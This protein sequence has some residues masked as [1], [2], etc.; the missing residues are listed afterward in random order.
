MPYYEWSYGCT[1]TSGAML[2][3]WWDAHH[4]FGR[5]TQYQVTRWD[6]VQDQYDHHVP[7]TQAWLANAMGTDSEGGTL[8]WNI[9]N[10]LIDVAEDLGYGC[11]SDGWWGP[12]HTSAQIFT[13]IAEQIDLDRPCMVSIP[14][15][16][17]VGVGYALEPKVVH[18]HDPNFGTLQTLSRS[19]LDGYHYAVLS[20]SPGVNVEVVS[21]NGGTEWGSNG[22]YTETL[23]SGQYFEVIWDCEYPANT[24]A[25]LYYNDEGG[26]D[27]HWELITDNTA[28]DGVYDWLVPAISS[29]QGN[30]TDFARLKVEIYD[31]NTNQLLG[32]DG[33]YGNF[34]ILAGGGLPVLGGPLV[35]VNSPAFYSVNNTVADSWGVIGVTDL[36][37]NGYDVWDMELYTSPQFTTLVETSLDM[38]DS[39]NYMV[40][41]NYQLSPQ[42]WGV[43]FRSSNPHAD[44]NVMFTSFPGFNLVSGSPLLGDWPADVPALAWNVYLEPGSYLFSLS[45]TNT[46]ADLNLALFQAGGNGIFNPRDAIA[47]ST[48]IGSA[49]E[50]FQYNISTAGYY[51]L[52]ASARNPVATPYTIMVSNSATWTGTLSNDWFTPGNWNTGVVPDL[53]MN[54]IIPSGAINSPLIVGGIASPAYV[55][56]LTIM[57]NAYMTVADGMI[58]VYGDLTVSG[59]LTQSHSNSVID[60]SGSFIITGSGRYIVTADANLYC[61]T[62]WISMV[63]A[64]AELTQGT[65]TFLSEQPGVID[66]DSNRV[67]FRNVVIN[68]PAGNFYIS[69]GCLEDVE[70]SNELRIET[71]SVLRSNSGRKIV[72]TGPIVKNGLIQLEN[73]I[74]EFNGSQAS[75]N[76]TTLDY[77]YSLQINTSQM[78]TLNTHLTVLKNLSIQAGGINAGNKTIY[79]GGDW[80]NL[81][82]TD[83]FIEGTSVVEFVGNGRAS[84]EGEHFATLRIDNPNCE[85]YFDTGTTLVDSYDW[86]AGTLHVNG[87]TLTIADLYDD[88]LTGRTIVSNGYL[89][90]TQDASQHIDLAGE[91]QIHGG[92]LRLSGGFGLSHWPWGSNASLTMTGGILHLPDGGIS[93][94]A[95]PY[96][97][98]ANLT[99]G[100]IRLA[101]SLIC[102]RTDFLPTGGTFELIPTGYNAEVSCAAPSKFA[103]LLIN[104]SAPRETALTESRDGN[105][106]R[107]NTVYLQS[108]LTLSGNLMVVSGQ[109]DLNGFTLNVEN[110]AEISSIL[111]MQNTYDLLIVDD[112][113]FWNSGSVGI[114]TTGEV[115]VN[116]WLVIEPEAEFQMAASTTLTFFGT[117]NGRISNLSTSTTFGNLNLDKTDAEVANNIDCLP[118]TVLGNLQINSTT[119]FYIDTYA[120]TVNGNLIGSSQTNLYLINGG[121]LTINGNFNTNGDMRV[122]NGA[123][124]CHGTYTHSILGNLELFQ[125]SF[126]LDRAFNSSVPHYISSHVL[127]TGGL[128]N[129]VHNA[130]VFNEGAVFEMTGGTVR[131]GYDFRANYAGNF[132]PVG[133]SVE[134]TGARNSTLRMVD[135]NWFYDLKFNKPSTSYGFVFNTSVTASNDVYVMGGVASLSNDVL[136]VGRDLLISGGRLACNNATDIINVGRNWTNTAGRTAFTEGP[137]TVNFVST[138]VGTIGSEDFNIVNINKGSAEINDLLIEAGAFVTIN[139]NLG[140]GGS[141]C[142][143]LLPGST[144]DLNANVNINGGLDITSDGATNLLYLAGDLWDETDG[145]ADGW[146]FK[147]NQGCTFIFNGSGDQVFGGDYMVGSETMNLFNVTVNKS[148][149]RVLPYNPYNIYGAFR[150]ISGEWYY[151]EASLAKNFHGDFLVE[152]NGIYSDNTGTTNLTGTAD[153]SF[154]A[155]GAVQFGILSFNKSATTNVNLTGDAI[156]S[157]TTAINLYAGIL[158]VGANTFRYK[159]SL[160]IGTNGKLNLSAGSVLKID[161]TSTLTVNAGGEFVSVGT[162][163]NPA[164][165]TSD[166]GYYT[167]T[168]TAINCYVAAQY[169]IFEKMGTSGIN[170][171]NRCSVDTGNVFRGCT[172]RNG[173]AGGTLLTINVQV[174]LEIYY[175]DFPANTWG[176]AY[177]VAR[178]YAVG[179]VTFRNY[180]GAFSGTAFHNSPNNSIF[181]IDLAPLAPQNLVIS[182]NGSAAV[183]SWD[184][185]TGVTGYHIYRSFDV[186]DISSAALVGTTSSTTWNDTGLP[187]N[188]KA[189]YFVKAYTE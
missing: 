21:P 94:D 182:Q 151:G 65:V 117:S 104:T 61:Y 1:P 84:C 136:S 174:P 25:K 165:V 47:S 78:N 41:N 111:I 52:I 18:I 126:T 90:I 157:G 158:N 146:G 14:E 12:Q 59:Q 102:T 39:Y 186:N 122:E 15:H 179:S 143:K 189:F 54:V 139:G 110:E 185:V 3:A 40:L 176:G 76:C 120:L 51:G 13:Q 168:A 100:T 57:S 75:L 70:I 156:L 148:A 173:I 28:N 181:W 178:S 79:I 53:N 180:T 161:D 124:L 43:K 134:L 132:V 119:D 30:F 67:N 2:F 49:G 98:T 6:P 184:A 171:G 112:G 87:G 170:L 63:S 106:T 154:K 187:A 89:Y 149:G 103:N 74:V 150:I 116:R 46:L 155:L 147:A 188:P 152:A 83:G 55:K 16:S 160:N 123:F 175:A 172:F 29:S 48:L 77:F 72:I 129:V 45:F 11:I 127:V 86:S 34:T 92:L 80:I 37:D 33:S 109:L 142:L 128:L 107:F 26:A 91:L 101:G 166:L 22:S 93:I 85:L 81:M 9:D 82:G 88:G 133:G 144:L 66:N 121:A 42:Y 115:R 137:G 162:S 32:S 10:G 5:F 4:G 58:N 99:G 164:L 145:V 8:V 19:Q 24:Y 118:I 56:S 169:T 130:I 62:N 95:S 183:L 35:T 68:K 50:S 44:A 159:G 60:V 114:I 177:N 125:G 140:I 64:R 23:V 73:G 7:D 96:T 36:T 71:G 108:D 20:G 113:L 131:T 17:V 97:F 163:S 105:P 153:C 135:G 27:N 141:S 38:Y 69:E 138:Q 167:F 31:S